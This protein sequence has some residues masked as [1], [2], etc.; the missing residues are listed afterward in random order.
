MFGAKFEISHFFKNHNNRM[1]AIIINVLLEKYCEVSANFYH[2]NGFS[3][4]IILTVL[5]NIKERLLE[6][7]TGRYN[8]QHLLQEI[9]DGIY[10]FLIN[11]EMSQN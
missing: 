4:I 8:F 5:E 11:V 7:T 9:T 6:S 10:W 3:H 1:M 2:V